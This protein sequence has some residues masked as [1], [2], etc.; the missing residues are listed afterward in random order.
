M[1]WQHGSPSSAAQPA[2]ASDGAAQPSSLPGGAEEPS[3]IQLGQYILG[4]LTFK[5][6]KHIEA[7]VRGFANNFLCMEL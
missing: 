7:F 3:F 5:N 2:L 6:I 1:R 4:E